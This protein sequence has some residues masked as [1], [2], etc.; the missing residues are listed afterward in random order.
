[1]LGRIADR[2]NRA[3]I[4]GIATMFWSA[5]VC[6]TGF[7]TNALQYFLARSLTGFAKSNTFVVQGPMIADGYPIGARARVLAV[8]GVVGR[9]GG[10]LAPL[11]VGGIVV[12]AGG[13]EGWRWA[14][15]LIGV[16]T[17]V[18]GAL[19]LRQPDPPRGQFEQLSTVGEVV[20]KVEG[21]PIALGAAYQR[22]MQIR[23][24]RSALFAFIAV[25]FTF[26][27]VP[28]LTNLYLEDEFDLSAFERALVTTVP[29]VVA[30]VVVPLVAKRF[31]H[32]YR[33]SP[34]RALVVVGALFIPTA[35]VPARSRC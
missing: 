5:I 27:T 20:D 29:G 12:L 35:R 34:P 32:V 14:F 26:I 6:V 10:L 23:T 8:H 18:I 31:D 22:I 17:F 15:G 7:I 2:G 4:V 13:D 11:A 24:Y 25:G 21:P 28:L 3:R 33:E 30:L 19:M 1:M 16:P 9:M